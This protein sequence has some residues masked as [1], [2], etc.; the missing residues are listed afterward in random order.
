[1]KSWPGKKQNHCV[2]LGHLCFPPIEQKTLDGW[3][4]QSF[5]LERDK[6]TASD[7]GIHLISPVEQ[8]TLDGWD[9]KSIAEAVQVS[10]E[11]SNIALYF[12]AENATLKRYPL[13]CALAQARAPSQLHSGVGLD[14]SRWAL[15]WSGDTVSNPERYG[16]ALCS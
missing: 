12:S 2:E 10:L 16:C 14:C 6:I 1:V 7:W 8:K 5:H 9:D 13:N 4:T 15:I 3:G 11:V